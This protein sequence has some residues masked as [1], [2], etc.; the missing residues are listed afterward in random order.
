M[1]FEEL[2]QAVPQ[3]ERTN[4]AVQHNGVDCGAFV[5]HYWE[6]EVRRF[7]GEGWPLSYPWTAGPIKAR[8]TRLISF[9]AQ[10]RRSNA[11]ME[12]EGEDPEAKGKAKKKVVVEQLLVDELENTSLSTA[13]LQML[14]LSELVVKAQGQGLVEFYGCSKCRWGRAGC[15]NYKCNPA[16]FTAH[17]E[18]FPE[19]YNTTEQELLKSITLTDVELIG[20]GS[21]VLK[22]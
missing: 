15:I 19:K 16:K 8:K 13:R 12:G 9:V 3:S 10:V 4:K 1:L 5:L 6:G 7:R 17:L 18:K 21:H 11:Q 22:L 2:G 14:E 20:G